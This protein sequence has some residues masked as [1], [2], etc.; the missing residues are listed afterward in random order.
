M[1]NLKEY[2]ERLENALKKKVAFNTYNRDIFHAF[3]IIHAAFK[4]AQEE[5]L[6]LSHE[7]DIA[8]YGGA[9]LGHEI[10]GFLGD[11]KGKM[12]ILVET[13]ISEAHP[14][15]QLCGEFS[16]QVKILRIPNELQKGYEFNFMVVDDFGYRF[17]KDR[18]EHAAVASFHD[19]NLHEAVSSLKAYFAFLEK[20]ARPLPGN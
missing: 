12:R 20:S 3:A 6:L 1:E 19:E 10:R 5:V 14:M 15:M 7:L 2:A 13:D 16:E 17:E 4:F 9:D 18:E 8:L 11:R